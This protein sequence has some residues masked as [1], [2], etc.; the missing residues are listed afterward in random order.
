LLGVLALGSVHGCQCVD[1]GGGG[2]DCLCDGAGSS[3][4]LDAVVVLNEVMVD[5]DGAD[6]GLEWVELFNAAPS[7]ADLS[8]WEIHWFKSDPEEESG[9]V[10]LPGGT[11]LHP[12]RFLLLGGELLVPAPGVVAELAIGNGDRGDGVHLYDCEMGLVDALVYSKD[13]DPVTGEPVNID[14]IIDESG[15]CATSVVLKPGQGSSLSRVEDGL[16][17]DRSGDDFCGCESPTPGASND[18]CCVSPP[19]CPVQ[20]TLM[21]SEL[22]PDPFAD[23]DATEYVEVFNAGTEAVPMACVVVYDSGAEVGAGRMA[24]E[25]GWSI[26]VDGYGLFSAD[27]DTLAGQVAA[28]VCQLSLGLTNTGEVWGVGFVD[29]DGNESISES[30]DCES[31]ACGIVQGVAINRAVA[32]LDEGIVGDGTWCDATSVFHSDDDGDHHGTPGAVNDA[33]PEIEEVWLD[34]G[35][36]VLTELMPQQPASLSASNAE[37]VEALNVS[38]QDIPLAWLSVVDGALS[39]QLTCDEGVETWFDG[40]LLLV[41]GSRSQADNGGIDV[42]CEAGFAL[43]D[44]G[45]S[46][47]LEYVNPDDSTTLLDSVTYDEDGWSY[48]PGVS[49]QLSAVHGC[50]SMESNDDPGCWCA[51]SIGYGTPAGDDEQLGTP[52]EP[53]LVCEGGPE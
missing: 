51:S 53:N 4:D 12:G 27:A 9:K 16:D 1:G 25:C 11:V 17:T 15:Q 47:G 23:Q 50:E 46:I 49:F 45:D 29:V 19:T 14:C 30:L 48:R 39:R 33:C 44:G 43:N 40:E 38:G 35:D 34:I 10:I 26:P 5:P 3:C 7:P 28:E 52:G 41:A 8:G 32:E 20:A 31:E 24:E 22:M 13:T 6:G 21:L 36:A 37:F 2:C 42:S 18:T